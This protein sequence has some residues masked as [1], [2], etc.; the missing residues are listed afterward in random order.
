MNDRLY[1]KCMHFFL[2]TIAFLLFF[3]S[4]NWN[5][6][7]IHND[8]IPVYTVTFDDI[9]GEIKQTSLDKSIFTWLTIL[10]AVSSDTP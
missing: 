1:L 3:K 4:L 10:E 5:F 6:S 8:N 7:L 9:L 2:T